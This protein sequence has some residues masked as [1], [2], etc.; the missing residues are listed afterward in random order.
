M[1]NIN[2]LMPVLDCDFNGLEITPCETVRDDPNKTE[3]TIIDCAISLDVILH[4][5]MQELWHINYRKLSE[6]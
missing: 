3:F 4:I 5:F 2:S 6:S 1:G